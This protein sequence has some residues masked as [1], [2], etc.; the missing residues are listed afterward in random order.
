MH[1]A[2][3][4]ILKHKIWYIWYFWRAQWHSSLHIRNKFLKRKPFWVVWSYFYY[5][6]FFINKIFLQNWLIIFIFKT[7]NDKDLCRHLWLGVKVNKS[8]KMWPWGR[9]DQIVKCHDVLKID[10]IYYLIIWIQMLKMFKTLFFSFKLLRYTH[11]YS[12]YKENR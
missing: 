10:H 8:K 9:L 3:L 11:A 2:H 12:R 4:L 7:R 5:F 6:F 1:N